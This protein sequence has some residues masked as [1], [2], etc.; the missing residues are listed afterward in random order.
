[1]T[2]KQ[3]VQAKLPEAFAYPPMMQEKEWRILTEKFKV[4][5]K[6]KTPRQAWASAAETV[7]RGK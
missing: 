3:I 5:G 6:G 7:R 2:P 4:L 1:M